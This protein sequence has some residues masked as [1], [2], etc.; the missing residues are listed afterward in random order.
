MAGDPDAIEFLENCWTL[1][2]ARGKED[3]KAALRAEC[4][5]GLNGVGALCYTDRQIEIVAEAAP[6]KKILVTKLD[7]N[8][9]IICTDKTGTPFRWNGEY[10]KLTKYVG[11][12]AKECS[13]PS[14][15]P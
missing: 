11:R 9:P 3:L 6:S 15:D 12:L 5:W 7:T 1:I 10:V 13:S 14:D 4:G 2:R 8:N